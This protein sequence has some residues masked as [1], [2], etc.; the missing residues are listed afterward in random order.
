MSDKMLLL[1]EVGNN[2]P[3]H[4]GYNDITFT[5]RYPSNDG[6]PWTL[7]KHGVKLYVRGWI[8]KM[9]PAVLA[10]DGAFIQSHRS[11]NYF[12]PVT[13]ALDKFDVETSS[14]FDLPQSSDI[15]AKK[16]HL[17]GHAYEKW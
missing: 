14:Y 5:E 6:F 12:V 9:S 2:R 7:I 3:V 13:V 17:D 10:R 1:S 16:V 8:I 11:T 15:F 4:C